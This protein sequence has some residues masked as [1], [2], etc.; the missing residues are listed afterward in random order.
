MQY[1]GDAGGSRTGG[2]YSDLDAF[3]EDETTCDTLVIELPFLDRVIARE[4]NIPNCA[5]AQRIIVMYAFSPSIIVSQ[6]QRYGLQRLRAPVAIEHI[7]QHCQL[8][9]TQQFDWQP[10]NGTRR[11]PTQNPFHPDASRRASWYDSPRS[12]PALN[13]N[14]HTT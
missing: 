14:V 10:P 6:L 5:G 2:A 13:V 4:L 12:R 11:R 7:W 9:H 8:I 1:R 3:L